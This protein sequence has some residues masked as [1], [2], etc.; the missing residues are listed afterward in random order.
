MTRG[1]KIPG[2]GLGEVL[3]HTISTLV[4]VADLLFCLRK[5]LVCRFTVPSERLLVIAMDAA[6]VFE[7]SRQMVLRERVALVC[8]EAVVAYGPLVILRQTG[9]VFIHRAN[10]ILRG[11]IALGSG[12]AKP[13]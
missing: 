1:A 2:M 13:R 3:L 10:L 12:F 11:S 5:I 7:H 8:R 4:K 6:A 9:F